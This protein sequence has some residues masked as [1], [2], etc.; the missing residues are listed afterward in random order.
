MVINGEKCKFDFSEHGIYGE[1][2]IIRRSRPFILFIMIF[3]VVDIKITISVACMQKY[4]NFAA[5]M[6]MEMC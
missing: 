5:S 2:V 1:C 3:G 4:S 6:E